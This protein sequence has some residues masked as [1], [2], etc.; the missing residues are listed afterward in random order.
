MASSPKFQLTVTL[1]DAYVPG[2]SQQD[3]VLVLSFKGQI[4]KVSSSQCLPTVPCVLRTQGVVGSDPL[5]LDLLHN[6]TVIGGVDCKAK[7]LLGETLV[8]ETQQWVKIPLELEGETKESPG[9][10]PA[11]DSGDSSQHRVARVQLV[12]SLEDKSRRSSRSP[13]KKIPVL[14]PSQIKQPCP[15]LDKLTALDVSDGELLERI[16]EARLDMG[17]RLAD[18]QGEVLPV[19]K[20]TLT[21]ESSS[22]LRELASKMEVDIP[23]IQELRLD[24]MTKEE[25]DR[26]KLALLALSD[27][28]HILASQD[29]E[30]KLLRAQ[31]AVNAQA[32]LDLQQTLT[33]TTEQLK[34]ESAELDKVLKTTQEERASAVSALHEK[35][36]QVKKLEGEGEV[37]R[38]S[39]AETQRSLQLAKA[40][41]T[42]LA[43]VRAE[44]EQLRKELGDELKA[45]KLLREEIEKMSGMLR[46]QAVGFT[47]ELAKQARL[48]E[49]LQGQL[50]EREA[51]NDQLHSENTALKVDLVTL[52]AQF[53]AEKNLKSRFTEQETLSK[54][55][56]QRVTELYAQLQSCEAQAQ[57][58]YIQYE[59]NEVR[60]VSEK[61]RLLEKLTE[62]ERTNEMKERNV[63]E[64]GRQ[65]HEA[66]HN[67]ATLEQ[68]CCVQ[69]DLHQLV[70]QMKAQGD[71]QRRG[72][73]SLLEE[74]GFLSE[75]TARQAQR[76]MEE[77]R[78]L[79]KYAEMVESQEEE[80]DDMKLQ[81]LQLQ[82]QTSTY[83]P[84][85]DDPVD[86]ALAEFLSARNQPLLVPFQRQDRDLYLFG[87]RRI[88]MKLENGRITGMI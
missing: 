49:A 25:F 76:S 24:Q 82:H 32:R 56:D 22:L 4:L 37:L 86:A 47:E 3:L 88:F 75:Q 9:S 63:E 50:K 61:L 34:K 30:V 48:K 12:L 1:N 62:A 69:E 10:Y 7:D 23:N 84:T 16:K 68:L 70:E 51:Q 27:K 28:A 35:H 31:A 20:L 73:D 46:A 14:T 15:Y 2:L 79:S 41:E 42:A 17:R 36:V 60:F 5:H 39:L 44:N 13:I 43:D 83:V 8:G 54:S 72:K 52:N 87:T 80:M 33:E 64:L 85:K 57:A 71:L 78:L 38:A 67:I 18:R 53:T 21:V 19:Q 45:K 65:L 81:V 26:V 77:S 58:R 55:L 59:E 6:K 29:Q 11:S 74:L 40:R 66:K